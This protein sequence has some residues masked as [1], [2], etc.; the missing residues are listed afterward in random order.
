MHIGNRR[1]LCQRKLYSDADE[2]V[3]SVKRPVMLN[4]ISAAVTAQ[5]LVDRT[6]TIETPVI[7]ERLE[8]TDLWREFEVERPRLLGALWIFMPRRWS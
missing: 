6:I 8:V 7:S 3:I 2:I 1:R 4:G 5:D